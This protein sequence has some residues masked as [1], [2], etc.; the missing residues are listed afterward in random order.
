MDLG[1]HSGKN[2]GGLS[3]R[4]SESPLDFSSTTNGGYSNW[5][6]DSHFRDG[7][8]D[9]KSLSVRQKLIFTSIFRCTPTY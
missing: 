6:H 1:H 5:N 9:S 4:S 7:M 8:Q 2:G 3:D